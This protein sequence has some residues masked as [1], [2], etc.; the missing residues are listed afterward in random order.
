[1]SR[2]KVGDFIIVILVHSIA[3][4][5]PIVRQEKAYAEAPLKYYKTTGSF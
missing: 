1:M 4:F 5:I 3:T 2:P